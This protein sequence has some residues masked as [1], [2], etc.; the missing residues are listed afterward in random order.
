MFCHT[1]LMKHHFE[2]QAGVMVCSHHYM[3]P[4]HERQIV[5][6]ELAEMLKLGIVEESYSAWCFPIVRSIWFCVKY[7]KMNEVPPFDAYPMTQVDKL[8]CTSLTAPLC[9]SAENCRS[10]RPGTVH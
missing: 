4:E 3:L 5:Q 6:N 1:N 2:T 10:M 8:L 9:T 7:C